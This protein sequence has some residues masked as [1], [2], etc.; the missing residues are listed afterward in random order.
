KGIVRSIDRGR[1]ATT[2]ITV[3]VSWETFDQHYSKYCRSGRICLKETVFHG[4]RR[5][6]LRDEH[7]VWI[8][9]FSRQLGKCSILEVELW[10][11]LGGL[12]IVQEKQVNKVLVQTN[13]L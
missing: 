4:P 5:G 12:S 7:G 13:S 1:G 3:V 11:I 8:I 9:G 6:T 2:S 10:G